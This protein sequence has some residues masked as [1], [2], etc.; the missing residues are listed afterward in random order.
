M[1]AALKGA[2]A[3][4][5]HAVLPPDIPA[6]EAVDPAMNPS[7]PVS[8]RKRLE[9]SIAKCL[10][11]TY[12]LVPP[13]TSGLTAAS[14]KTPFSAS[15]DIVDS[16]DRSEAA[17][18]ALSVTSVIY[19]IIT[20]AA[21]SGARAAEL[22]TAGSPG[23]PIE[24]RTVVDPNGRLTHLA[25]S[26]NGGAPVDKTPEELLTI[27]GES[28]QP[29]AGAPAGPP[30][31]PVEPGVPDA[32]TA[33]AT[34]LGATLVIGEGAHRAMAAASLNIIGITIT[35]CA[36]AAGL[37]GAT[38]NAPE[39][40]RAAVVALAAVSSPPAAGDGPTLIAAR[41]AAVKVSAAFRAVIAALSQLH[42]PIIT[43]AAHLS[44]IGVTPLIPELGGLMADAIARSE[45]AVP[46]PAPPPPP[47]GGGL[48][49]VAAAAVAAALAAAGIA[50]SPPADPLRAE[51]ERLLGGASALA[52]VEREAAIQQVIAQLRAAGWTPPAAPAAPPHAHGSSP[53]PS[54]A[55]QA[56]RIAGSDGMAPD[57]VVAA[58]AGAFGKPATDFTAMLAKACDGPEP[59]AFFA[60]DAAL[61]AAKAATYFDIVVGDRTFEARPRDWREAGARLD[62]IITARPVAPTPHSGGHGAAGGQQQGA[63]K[64]SASGTTAVNKATAKTASVGEAKYRISA[65]SHTVS[66][67]AD[68]A[69]IDAELA[70]EKLDDPIAELARMRSTAY[71][72][73]AVPYVMS[74]GTVSGNMPSTGTSTTGEC[75]RPRTP[76]PP[77]P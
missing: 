10:D 16:V 52:S 45:S 66:P 50:A 65:S 74:D 48:T 61:S 69:V 70:A 59:S 54:I 62:G 29:W 71:G 4:L 64:R 63:A 9:G 27:I 24:V 42:Q 60:G 2:L 7:D 51:A 53:P 25:I 43:A 13:V 77:L 3:E 46:P 57:E 11:G 41:A 47:P 75:P 23:L 12:L 31:F 39:H 20:D 76:T 21:G 49:A 26:V 28:W 35:S 38:A 40:V 67:L 36:D 15:G 5:A 14:K 55:F 37:L 30:P 58:I 17:V 33:A 68:Q 32:A 73:A 8:A 72:A 56:L 22:K 1:L 18:A 34:A 44:S 6:V 19:G